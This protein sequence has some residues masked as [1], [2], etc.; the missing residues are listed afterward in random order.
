MKPQMYFREDFANKEECQI[1]SGYFDIVRCRT[2][3][4]K[5]EVPVVCRYS[6]LP[7]NREL[8]E[9]LRIIGVRP[10]NSSSEH[11]YIAEMGWI[12]DIEDYTFPTYSRLQD[13]CSNFPVVIKGKTNSRKFEWKTKMFAEN[14]QAA[15][16]I[17]SELSNDP[18]IGPQGLVYRKYIPLE[19]L[20]I[21]V[22]G[23]PMTNEWRCFFLGT[24]LVSYGYYWS[25]LNDKSLVD[26][27]DF[28]RGGLVVAKEVA[29]IVSEFTNFFVL[30]IAK[31]VDGRW[32]V[33]EVNDGQM[34]GLSD[35]D[36]DH[37]YCELAKK[38][39]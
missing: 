1:A 16:E 39:S 8:E 20:E 3:L 25:S 18:L 27:D 21:G 7:F 14:L 9:D 38:L 29:G 30:D 36:P 37:F 28:E 11:S 34:S 23:M 6:A 15:I 2:K 10:I 5:S 17:S 12:Y 26:R 33:V 24:E 31:G 19:T 22:N 35:I 13:V 32:W 4:V